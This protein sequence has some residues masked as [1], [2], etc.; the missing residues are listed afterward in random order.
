M[1]DRLFII[2]SA[3]IGK[4]KVIVAKSESWRDRYHFLSRFD[5][6]VHIFFLKICVYQIAQCLNDLRVK[7][8]GP[9]SRHLSLLLFPI[10]R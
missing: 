3:I 6:R 4:G 2:P 7:L 9:F 8:R 1:L 10:W 5:C